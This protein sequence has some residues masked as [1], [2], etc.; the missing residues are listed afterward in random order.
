MPASPFGKN[1]RTWKDM[2]DYVVHFAK[3]YEGKDAYTSMLS[4]L[5]NRVIRARNPFG[6]CRN[7]APDFSSQKSVC[8]S[9]IPLHLLGRLAEKRSEYGIV[10]RK[11]FVIHS[12]GNPILYAYKDQPITAAIKK[13]IAAAG[14]DAS[15]PIWEVTPFIDSPGA[16][17]TG[18]YFF[19]W[20]R[21]WRKVGDF[22]F[23]EKNVAF[24]IIPEHLHEAARAFFLAARKENLGPCY[25][26]PFID[27]HWKRKMIK[28]L[29]PDKPTRA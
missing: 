10:F 28:P 15:S 18:S 1:S 24:L 21:E 6:I 19:E 27:A 12:G 3:D 8:F 7:K 25:D 11:D 22:N 16:Y 14:N 20:K 17:P 29:L 13:L 2:S 4:I 23:A 26:C 9:E 5:S